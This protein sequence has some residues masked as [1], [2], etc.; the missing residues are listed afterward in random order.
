MK[1]SPDHPTVLVAK[2][3]TSLYESAEQAGEIA[4]LMLEKSAAEV[5][6]MDLRAITSM[7]DCFVI[8]TGSSAAQVKAIVDHVD[9][10][11]RKAGTKPYHIEGYQGLVWVVLDYV[12]VVAHIFM[13]MEREYYHL[14][15]LWADADITH[16]KDN[17]S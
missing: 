15:R 8:A 7:T 2:A 11:M 17:L 1:K 6:I 14:E 3:D 5:V 13:P 4:Q 16:V 12:H 10:S 9:D